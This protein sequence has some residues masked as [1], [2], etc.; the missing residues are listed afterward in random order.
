[1]LRFLSLIALSAFLCLQGPSPRAAWD[2][3]TSSIPAS[4]MEL[5]VV[6]VEGCIYCSVFRRD[7]L[8]N[9]QASTQ[10]QTVPIRV[11]ELNA[12]E[13]QKFPFAEPVTMV[14]TIL[15][16]KGGREVGRISGYLGPENF[17]H[18]VNHMISAAP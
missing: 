14:P 15:L 9:Y 12:A 18:A 2:L 8:P 6:E 4:S 13:E 17:F 16:M 3:E 11:I 5:L 10:A 1:M 7:V